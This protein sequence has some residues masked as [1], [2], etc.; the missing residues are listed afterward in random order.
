MSTKVSNF[1]RMDIKIIIV[2]MRLVVKFKNWLSV[3]IG[4]NFEG[5]MQKRRGLFE[6]VKSSLIV[7]IIARA[8]FSVLAYFF[9]DLQF[10]LVD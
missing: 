2:C 4:Y 6:L 8:H 9:P 3:S 1:I 7:T 10:N 5:S